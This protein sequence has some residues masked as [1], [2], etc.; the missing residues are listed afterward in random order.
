MYL[1]VL[2]LTLLT[3]AGTVYPIDNAMDTFSIDSLP[4]FQGNYKLLCT[5]MPYYFLANLKMLSPIQS[6]KK[7]TL[8]RGY[9]GS[10]FFRGCFIWEGGG[11]NLI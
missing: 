4:I 2:L 3:I 6:G 8:Y 9:E 1:M 7:T 5:M 10:S 11:F